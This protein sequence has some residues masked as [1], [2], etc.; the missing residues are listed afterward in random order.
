MEADTP[1]DCTPTDTAA[2]HTSAEAHTHPCAHTATRGHSN[3][4]THTHT[5]TRDVEAILPSQGA[6]HDGRLH[7]HIHITTR[8]T[9]HPSVLT[10]RPSEAVPQKRPPHFA[11]PLAYGQAT[12]AVQ[13][14]RMIHMCMAVGSYP[15]RFSDKLPGAVYPCCCS[16]HLPGMRGA[17]VSL[18]LLRPAAMHEPCTS[19]VVPL[20]APVALI[21]SHL[22]S[23]RIKVAPTRRTALPRAHAYADKACVWCAAVGAALTGV[24][25]AHALAIWERQ[26]VL[27]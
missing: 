6:V 13:S 14:P 27:T 12:K 9:K 19:H 3:T 15:W 21:H 7:I 11:T 16:A 20:P 10:H 5:H 25:G 18:L 22:E 24:R 23:T 2:A 8:C 17:D 1:K 26:L 4:R